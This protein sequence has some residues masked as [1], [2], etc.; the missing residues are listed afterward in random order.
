MESISYDL[1]TKKE[2]Q[3]VLS[4]WRNTPGVHLHDNGEDSVEGIIA[5]LERN[6]GLSF[7]ARRAGKIVGAV[8]CG[9][10][11]RRGI[12]HHLAVDL[13]FRKMGIGKTLLQMCIEQLREIKIKKCL[14]FVLKDNIEAETF[15]R[16]LHW[17]EETIV[18][19]YTTVI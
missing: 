18:K 5:Y 7:V 14:L 9:H 13:Q 10:D 15:Y 17:Q 6:P 19:V 3:E 2:C 11:G 1:F 8:I 12:V 16:S 4:L